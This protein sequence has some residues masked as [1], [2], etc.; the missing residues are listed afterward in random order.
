MHVDLP[1]G[2]PG[3]GNTEL[4]RLSLLQPLQNHMFL[5]TAWL[6]IYHLLSHNSF[7]LILYLLKPFILLSLLLLLLPPLLQLLIPPLPLPPLMQYQWQYLLLLLLLLPPYCYYHDVFSPH[8][9][10]TVL[11]LYHALLPPSPVPFPHDASPYPTNS[12]F[13]GR[14]SY[15][16]YWKKPRRTRM[17]QRTS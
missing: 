2:T 10:L 7:I 4:M 5:T 3:S 16:T 11:P 9:Y 6:M 15:E 1:R 14:T 8:L 13:L 12:R 17:Y